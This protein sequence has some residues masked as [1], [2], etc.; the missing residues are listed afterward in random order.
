[1]TPA[2]YKRKTRRGVIAVF[3][4]IVLLNHPGSVNYN[5]LGTL[6]VSPIRPAEP[7]Y[8]R[9]MSLRTSL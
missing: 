9:V 7:Q 4:A 6:R 8:R 5:N 3:E 1:V 2:E